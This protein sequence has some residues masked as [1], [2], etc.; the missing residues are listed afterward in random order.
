MVAICISISLITYSQ[1]IKVSV[2]NENIGG[3]NN[4]ALSVIIIHPDE[5]TVKKE[6][7]S[8]IKSYK[9]DNV[10]SKKEIFADNCKISSISENTIDIYARVEKGKGNT[11]KLIVG[12]DLG[13]AYLNGSHSGYKAAKKMLY[14]FAVKLTLAGV[15]DELKEEEKELG[16]KEK[17]LVKLKKSNDKL[18]NNIDGYKKAIEQAKK[19]IEQAKKDIETNLKDQETSKKEIE[20]Q[21]KVVQQVSDKLKAVK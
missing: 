5:S 16:K 6:W 17:N 8:L 18:H 4:A 12:F 14:E 1:K 7:K 13:G 11:V 9:S 19:D 3:G 2:S 21:K 20:S 10:Q 15:E